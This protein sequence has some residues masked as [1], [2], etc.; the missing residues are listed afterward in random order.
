MLNKYIRV[1]LSWIGCGILSYSIG[2]YLSGETKYF[3]VLLSIAIFCY[4]DYH[5]NEFFEVD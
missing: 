4:I 3:L 1:I 2:C 5:S